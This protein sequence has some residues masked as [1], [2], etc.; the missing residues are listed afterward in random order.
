MRLH[1][2]NWE[3]NL[4]ALLEGAG[5][6]L[7]ISPFVSYD[8]VKILVPYLRDSLK[9]RLLTR[10]NEVDFW[11]GA[12]DLEALDLLMHLKVDVKSLQN[13]HA[14]VYVF[15]CQKAI[16][17]SANFTVGGLRRNL[18]WGLLL[19]RSECG[20]LF[21]EAEELWNRQKTLHC[22][23]DVI[24]TREKLKQYSESHARP[25][26]PPGLVD[27]SEPDREQPISSGRKKPPSPFHKIAIHPLAVVS[28]IRL[29]IDDIVRNTKHHELRHGEPQLAFNDFRNPKDG[30]VKIRSYVWL[31]GWCDTG[32]KYEKESECLL[33]PLAKM[34]FGYVPTSTIEVQSRHV[35]LKLFRG[36]DRLEDEAEDA[37]VEVHN[38]DLK[39]GDPSDPYKPKRE[40]EQ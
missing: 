34:L 24:Q 15:D 32:G 19:E 35:N 17:T 29:C 9:C 8:A 37:L 1:R 5:D 39:M 25:S 7:I 26:A 14:K 27:R 22:E 33:K 23:A 13:L 38:A 16:L 10:W 2:R 36:R 21:L 31:A 3:S 28:D 40:C 20:E 30:M 12:S 6:L 18:E 4:V 11:N